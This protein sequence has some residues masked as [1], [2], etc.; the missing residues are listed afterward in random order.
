MLNAAMKGARSIPPPIDVEDIAHQ[1]QNLKRDYN[2]VTAENARMKTRLTKLS[3]QAN[4]KE[5]QLINLNRQLLK[6]KHEQ[7]LKHPIDIVSSHIGPVVTELGANINDTEES[8]M[9]PTLFQ[10]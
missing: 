5:D 3:S 8:T 4:T 9:Q 7:R 2:R 6:I 1:Y 10:S